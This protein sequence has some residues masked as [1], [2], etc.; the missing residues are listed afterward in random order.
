M[1]AQD[2]PVRALLF[3]FDG[4]LINSLPVMQLAFSAALQEVYPN[5]PLQHGALFTEYRKYLGMGF[6]EIMNRLN[7][8]Q[9]MHTPFRRHSRI[10]APYV[11]LYDGA[12]DLLAWA[13]ARGL[14]MGIATGKD[15]ERTIELLT[16]LKIRDYFSIVLASDTVSAPKPAPEMAQ[17]FAADCDIGLDHIMLIGD[18]AADLHCGQAAG[19]RTAAAA[20]GYT[21][22]EELLALSPDYVFD[23]PSDAQ[24]Q[25]G[26][27][28]AEGVPAR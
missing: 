28:I 9:D 10:L 27:M 19:C 21:A 12:V 15:Y 23:T 16:Q 6:P 26:R 11:R 18:A 20:W 17:R 13:H 14:R 7:L 5:Q 8:S 25:L 1:T 3:D 4:V 2:Q 22:K 24:E